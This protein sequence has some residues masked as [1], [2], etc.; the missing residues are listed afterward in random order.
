MK[1]QAAIP[2]S[3][4]LI[5]TIGLLLTLGV[6]G[7]LQDGNAQTPDVGDT[8]ATATL[9]A[10]GTSYPE[11]ID[12]QG[13]ED[14]FRIVV[15]QSG[16]LKVWT[17]GNLD[18][19]GD[20]QNSSGDTIALNNNDGLNKNFEIFHN[21]EPGTYYL[22]VRSFPT[23]IGSYTVY[24]TLERG[25]F[26]ADAG[27][28]R[29]TAT[30]LALDTDFHAYITP[31]DDVDYFRIVVGQSGKLAVWTTGNL[32]IFGELQTEDGTV[33]RSNDNWDY[34]DNFRIV[35]NVAAGTYY[36]KV[37]ENWGNTG[38][39]V[40][41][42]KLEQGQRVVDAGDTPETAISLVA[43]HPYSEDMDPMDDVDYFRI[44][45]EQSDRLTVWTTGAL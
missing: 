19:V 6:L 18:T 11:D 37:E 5:F 39:Y 13:D 2:D 23:M 20:L 25:V 4:V 1:M 29:A 22:R 8:R 16:T 10:L 45:V 43:G 26:I 27:D 32:D 12:V 38:S 34:D 7:N 33:L 36:L 30:L 17:T 28:T 3:F 35:Y 14:Y 40:V 44:V 41:Q 42:A 24:A 31:I 15:G 9:L 21:V